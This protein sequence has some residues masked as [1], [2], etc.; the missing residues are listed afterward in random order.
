MNKKQYEALDEIY[1]IQTDLKISF[2]ELVGVLAF[3]ILQDE[4]R[5]KKEAE[6]KPIEQ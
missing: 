5:R 3:M 2:G 6:E 4:E 1:K